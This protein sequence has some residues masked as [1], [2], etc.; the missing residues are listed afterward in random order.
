MGKPIK[1]GFSFN[2]DK[3]DKSIKTPK[4]I[5][6]S[7]YNVLLLCEYCYNKH[8]RKEKL[9]KICKIGTNL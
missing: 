4:V 1:G 6:V 5:S 7:Q 3:C 8:M 2:C 9:E